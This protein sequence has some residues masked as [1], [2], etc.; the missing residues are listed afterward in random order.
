MKQVL[1]NRKTV[2]CTHC[3]KHKVWYLVVIFN[4]KQF[5]DKHCHAQWEEKQK[6]TKPDTL[7]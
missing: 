1:D 6:L 2:A 7:V 4:M 3:G 5:C